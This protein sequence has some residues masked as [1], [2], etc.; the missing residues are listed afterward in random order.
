MLT[1]SVSIDGCA[2]IAGSMKSNRSPVF[3]GVGICA[4]GLESKAQAGHQ[5]KH[6]VGLDTR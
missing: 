5:R 2:P 1:L 6:I 3:C 4:I